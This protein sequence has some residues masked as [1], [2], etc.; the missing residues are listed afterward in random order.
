DDAE[1]RVFL[2]RDA[3]IAAASVRIQPVHSGNKLDDLE[4][5]NFVIEPADLCFVQLLTSPRFGIFVR[6]RLDDLLDLP[7]RGH[8]FFLKFQKGFL[9]GE[10][11]LVRVLKNTKP[12]AARADAA[13]AR[14][15]FSAATTG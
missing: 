15:A 8:A 9:G 14:L 2:Q 1:R 7:P 5:F 6:Q 13:A 10:A 11:R 12:P 3:V 4:L